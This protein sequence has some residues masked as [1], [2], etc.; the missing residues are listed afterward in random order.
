MPWR[1]SCWST[2]ILTR[3]ETSPFSRGLNVTPGTQAQLKQG[4]F[5]APQQAAVDRAWSSTAWKTNPAPG[6]LGSVLCGRA[7]CVQG[8]GE[9]YS[10]LSVHLAHIGLSYP[11]GGSRASSWASPLHELL[12]S[13]VSLNWICVGLLSLAKGILVNP[14]CKSTWINISVEETEVSDKPI[15]LPTSTAFT[16]PGSL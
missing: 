11:T 5:S 14:V 4:L 6:D 10:P 16:C 8:M 2:R 12:F 9:V 1:G 7:R 15:G 13:Q 3:T